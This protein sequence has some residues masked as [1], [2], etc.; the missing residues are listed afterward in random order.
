MAW[1]DGAALGSQ[2]KTRILVLA[3]G[4]ATAL[5]ARGAFAQKSVVVN[6]HGDLSAPLDCSACHTAQSFVPARSDMAFD[7][8]RQTRFPLLGRHSDVSC[9]SCHLGLRFD[10]PDFAANE[11]AQCH[12][13][14]HQGTLSSSCAGCHNTDSF[15]DVDGL[16]VH[17]S[18]AFPLTGAHEQISCID[19]HVDGAAGTFTAPDATCESCHRD[20]YTAAA[21][22]DHAGLGFPLT[23]DQCHSTLA[24]LGSGLFDHVTASGG[25]ALVGAHEIA[26]CT[27]C[28]VA[29]GFETRFSAADADDCYSCHAA[30]YEEQHGGSGFPTT[31]STCHDAQSWDAFEGAF[32]HTLAS[33]GFELVGAHET[34][35]CQSCH[36]MPGYGLLFQAS[37]N[38]D[39]F[40]CHAA[41]YEANHAGSGFPSTCSTCHGTETWDPGSSFD[42]TLAS[43]GFELVGAHVI[44]A[45]ESCHLQPGFEPIFEASGSDDCY[46]CHADD[47]QATHAGSGFPTTCA[48]C[49][50]TDGWAG[51]TLANHDADYFP[52]YS[53]AHRGE[54]SSCQTCHT[55]AADYSVFTCLSCH[56]HRQSAMDDKHSG[57]SGYAYDSVLCLS[58][59]PR[60]RH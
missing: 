39:C 31:C 2:M 23:C 49:H 60:G 19:C 8:N 13:D 55:N 4:L 5:A 24:W 10:E 53:G 42:H 52:I 22:V 44:A 14:V 50:G 7:H 16:E 43:N 54:W 34:A 25:F 30:D 45:C 9:S 29:P 28:H 36:T 12:V 32:D 27:S 3:F 41:D 56:E 58:C 20:D 11:C 33:G 1:F 26:R 15:Q 18:T 17:A 40:G 35:A 21:S 51:A 38:D 48:T 37:T 59:H 6:P 57:E 46:A 47:Y